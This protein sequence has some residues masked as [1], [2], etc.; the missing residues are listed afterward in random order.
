MSGGRHTR[1][2]RRTLHVNGC[3]I[4]VEDKVAI[5]TDQELNDEVTDE[6]QAIMKQKSNVSGLESS[7]LCQING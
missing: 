4:Y 1:Y 2:I 7:L 3:L 6:C 5:A